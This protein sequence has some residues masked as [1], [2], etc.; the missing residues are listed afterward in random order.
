MDG[1]SLD[2]FGD[3][4]SNALVGCSG[5]FRSTNQNY[6]RLFKLTVRLL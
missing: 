1:I 2:Y 3:A 5:A 6:I 4:C